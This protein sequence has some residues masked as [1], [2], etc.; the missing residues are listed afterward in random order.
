MTEFNSKI[1]KNSRIIENKSNL[2]KIVY[3]MI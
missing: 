1:K 3:I 2:S